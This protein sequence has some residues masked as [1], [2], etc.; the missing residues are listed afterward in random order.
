MY[1]Q[2]MRESD[3][4]PARPSDTA[5]PHAR[6]PD[7]AAV[8]PQSSS[9]AA[10]PATGSHQHATWWPNGGPR[11]QPAGSIPAA[12]PDYLQPLPASFDAAGAPAGADQ[13]E[14]GPAA[15]YLQSPYPSASV[16]NL[17]ASGPQLQIRDIAGDENSFTRGAMNMPAGYVD[18]STGARSTGSAVPP[19]ADGSS[20]RMPMAAAVSAPGGLTSGHGSCNGSAHTGSTHDATWDAVEN[21]ASATGSDG[22]GMALQAAPGV[23]GTDTYL[24][25]RPFDAA[26]GQQPFGTAAGTLQALPG[27]AGMTI[28]TA[29]TLPPQ[30]D[31]AGMTVRTAVSLPGQQGAAGMPGYG[32]AAPM[33]ITPNAASPQRG[34]DEDG[35]QQRSALD[36]YAPFT[37]EQLAARS[38]G[39]AS[40]AAA[41]GGAYRLTWHF[42]RQKDL[43]TVKSLGT[44]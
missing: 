33:A 12:Q 32:T 11:Q 27:A 26:M 37:A 18:R 25:S 40:G 44:V 34:W 31:G 5:H 35:T 24:Q 22:L 1:T 2:V 43:P 19:A 38:D 9:A 13:E 39:L 42:S 23:N 16:P 28:H 6:G 30:S 29:V 41:A 7:P 10:G 20:Q 8:P 15:S 21:I 14:P 3:R 36:T 4:A 17:T